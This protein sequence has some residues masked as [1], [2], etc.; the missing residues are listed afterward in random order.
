[1]RFTDC[2]A[3]LYPEARRLLDYE[4]LDLRPFDPG[5]LVRFDGRFHRV[6]DIWR[7]PSRMVEMAL[8]PVGTTADK[9]RLIALRRRA[10]WGDLK[11]LYERPETEALSMLKDLGFSSRIIERF[12]KP[13]FAGVF[14]D[15]SSAYR[16]APSS[17]SSAPSPSGTPPYP[18]AVWGRSLRSS[19]PSFRPSRFGSRH[20]FASFWS[21][22]W[23]WSP[24]SGCRRVLW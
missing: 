23:C 21:E 12:F 9:L 24:A 3:N 15:P 18:L 19:P 22:K 8:S 20:G 2:P 13:F 1:M 10:L 14:F 11:E 6:T 5:A 4:A 16:A 7:R 17:S